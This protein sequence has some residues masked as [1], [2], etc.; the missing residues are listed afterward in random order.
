MLLINF[1]PDW[2]FHLATLAGILLLVTSIVLGFIPFISKFKTPLLVL[3]VVVMSA[4]LFFEG[5]LYC[6][7]QWN[8]K[9]AELERKVAAAEVA[10]AKQNTRIVTKY[11]TNVE[12]IKDTTDENIKLVEQHVTGDDSKCTVPN[13][14]VVLHD[15]ASKNQLPPS[16]G[17]AYEGASDVKISE[18]TTTV[19]ENYG[20]YYQ[21]SEQ[22]KAWQE[23]YKTQKD[24]FEK[25]FN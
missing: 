7:A 10:S 16:T 12:K 22:L 9:V 1:I 8:E 5:T 4:G 14:V 17:G 3:G 24:I 23:W 15:S 6:N 11:I 18:L 13:S 20:T 25:A 2:V 21:I 19:V